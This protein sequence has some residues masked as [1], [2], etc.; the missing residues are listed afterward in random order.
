[1]D[2]PG[3]YPPNCGPTPTIGDPTPYAKIHWKTPSAAV[4]QLWTSSVGSVCFYY[5]TSLESKST[6]LG[7]NKCPQTHIYPHPNTPIPHSD[8]HTNLINTTIDPHHNHPALIH[9]H[10][11]MATLKTSISFQK[12]SQIHIFHAS[13]LSEFRKTNRFSRYLKI[14][15]LSYFW[16]TV[17][18][19]SLC[20]K[21]LLVCLRFN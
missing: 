14:G 13:G 2:S 20:V 7:E 6:F 10:N 19:L 3:S 12:L 4:F 17:T 16:S 1:M 15:I 21:S 5:C 11:K 18:G 8:L 9:T